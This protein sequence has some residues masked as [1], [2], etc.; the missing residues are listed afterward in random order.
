MTRPDNTRGGT[1]RAFNASCPSAGN[2]IAAQSILTS[3]T[4]PTLRRARHRPRR[5]ERA[6]RVDRGELDAIVGILE[7]GRD[8][9]HR[10]GGISIPQN[11]N[12]PNPR[13]RVLG[14]E[15]GRHLFEGV[16]L[17]SDGPAEAGP[18]IAATHRKKGGSDPRLRTLDPRLWTLDHGLRTIPT[19]RHVIG[20]RRERAPGT[21]PCM[22]PPLSRSA[23]AFP[24][25]RPC[26]PP[27]PLPGRGR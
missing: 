8:R 19:H 10:L 6:F 24:S 23:R 13:G 15:P 21:G 5:E 7:R 3:T 2:V 22:T 1:E 12:R 4:S 27:P 25:R 17:R 18:D 9:L 11:L 26:P 14:L 20:Q 16:L